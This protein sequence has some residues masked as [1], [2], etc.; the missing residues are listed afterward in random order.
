MT[1]RFFPRL[2]IQRA[3]ESQASRVPESLGSP[4]RLSDTIGPGV[5]D[6]LRRLTLPTST[7]VLNP[8]REAIHNPPEFFVWDMSPRLRTNAQAAAPAIGVQL[9]SLD[10]CFHRCFHRYL[11]WAK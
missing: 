11:F 3:S 1:S 10:H 4:P 9:H 7:I 5:V 2:V 6:G 8:D